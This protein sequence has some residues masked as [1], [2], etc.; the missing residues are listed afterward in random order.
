[1]LGYLDQPE[2]TASVLKKHSDGFFW[3]HTGD[4]VSMDRDGFFYFKLRE[5]RMIKSSG[6]NV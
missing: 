3:L 4:I 5:K 1:M 2:E 6:M